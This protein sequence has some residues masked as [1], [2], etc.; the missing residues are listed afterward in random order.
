RDDVVR[1]H[2]DAA[3]DCGDDA[4]HAHRSAHDR[5]LRY[6]RDR[7][8]VEDVHRDAAEMAGSER[9]SPSGFFS[10]EVEHGEQSLVADELAAEFDRILL[11]RA[12]DLVD[13]A[14]PEE[15]V[16]GIADRAPGADRD[17]KVH[18]DEIDLGVRYGVWNRADAPDRVGIEIVLAD[19]ER[20]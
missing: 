18:L 4:V 9:L 14:L 5:N 15:G 3:V 19:H 20:H 11:A 13:E 8:A 6:L 17:A 10:G 7:R 16:P 2:D 12:R 1:T